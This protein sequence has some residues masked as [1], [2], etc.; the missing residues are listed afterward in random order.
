MIKRLNIITVLL[1]SVVFTFAGLAYGAQS[2][3]TNTNTNT[4]NANALSKSDMRFM[5]KAA[6]G[7]MFEV[8][9]GNLAKQR[10]SNKDVKSF[11]E[12][13]VNDHSK[14]NDQLM[15]L[16]SDNGVT[17]PKDL[18]AKHK[19]TVDR[20]SNLSGSQF[21]REYMNVMVKDH[22]KDVNEFQ[23]ESNRIQNSDLKNWTD[24]T[25]STIKDHL[26]QAK[27]IEQEVGS[28]S[29]ASTK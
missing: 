11:G 26:Q 10:A 19:K 13:M 28:K 3:E 2:Q 8:H 4:K 29:S 6:E 1:V 27:N 20:L 17:L 21:D 12:R 18:D 15:R 14:A 5:K 24:D 9:L 16:A 23:S 7:G 22:T 25:L